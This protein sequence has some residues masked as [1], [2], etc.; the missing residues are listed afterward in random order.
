MSYDLAEMFSLCVIHTVF[1]I[2]CYIITEYQ[3]WSLES[4]SFD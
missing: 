3:V 4:E 1:L 2:V